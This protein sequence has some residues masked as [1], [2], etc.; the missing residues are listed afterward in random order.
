M[1]KKPTY[2]RW[3]VGLALMVFIW[4]N[5]DNL[6]AQSMTERAKLAEIEAL[7]GPTVVVPY[8]EGNRAIGDNCTTPIVVNI[9]ADLPFADMANT[10]CG[11]GNTY[12]NSHLG[13]YDGGEDII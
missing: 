13:N 4:G 3:L 10:T 9:P 6:Y 5:S 8:S 2:W 11:R 7:H 12:S 1:N